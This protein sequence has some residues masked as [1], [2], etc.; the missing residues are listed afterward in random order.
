MERLVTAGPD[1]AHWLERAPATEG[2]RHPFR[3]RRNVKVALFISQA[4]CMSRVCRSPQCLNLPSP[5]PAPHAHTLFALFSGGDA[6]IFE[7]P[8]PSPADADEPPSKLAK[9]AASSGPD[10]NRTG[11]KALDDGGGAGD[12]CL[13]G[14]QYHTLGLLRTKPGRGPRSHSMSCSDK[15][16]RWTLLGRLRGKENVWLA[17]P[18]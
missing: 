10:M 17:V 5:S 1:S 15:L 2:S 4:P 7:L 13:P 12:P 8:A 3:L 18:A 6:S 14:V 9:R 16:L 11:A